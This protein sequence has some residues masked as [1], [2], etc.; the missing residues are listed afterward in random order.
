V[1]VHACDPSTQEDKVG[2]LRVQGDLEIHSK[3]LSPKTEKK[4]KTKKQ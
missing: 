3:T 2:G 4:K 1:V